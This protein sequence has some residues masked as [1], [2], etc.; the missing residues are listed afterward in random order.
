MDTSR[1]SFGEKV[2]A[3]SGLA[4][5]V[6]MFFNWFGYDAGAGFGGAESPGL[7]AWEWM[8]FLDILLFLAGAIAVA[9]AVARAADA[10]PDLP[11]PPGMVVAAAGGLAFLIVL[12]RLLAPGDGPLDELVGDLDA[13]RE[14]GV[15]LGLIAS[16]GIAF[17]GYAAMNERASGA[18]PG[19]R[20]SATPPPPP[21][22]QP[23]PDRP[24]SEPPSSGPPSSGPPA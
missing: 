13:T 14:L 7:T 10:M 2:A 16:A 6:L 9:L 15:F 4:L 24:P 12:F 22:S 17:G 11:W 21:P 8:S 3:A 5:I 19:T 23:P 18:A 1:I 20:T